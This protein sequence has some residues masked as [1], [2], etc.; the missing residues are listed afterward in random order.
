MKSSA[1][2]WP[3]AR[4][5]KSPYLFSI[6]RNKAEVSRE[7]GRIKELRTAVSEI[8]EY[9]IL[10]ANLYD[11]AKFTLDTF[12]DDSSISNKYMLIVDERSIRHRT[13]ILVEI[14]EQVDLD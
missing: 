8:Q 4:D 14:Q 7:Q 6:F 9:G 2:A 3:W 11:L 12:P 1:A 5:V 10:N 13:C